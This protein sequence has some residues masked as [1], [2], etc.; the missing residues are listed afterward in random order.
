MLNS[1]IVRDRATEFQLLFFCN[2]KQ[3]KWSLL[4]RASEH[5]FAARDF[6]ERCD[7]KCNTLTLVK[8]ANHCIFGGYTG[9]KWS[10]NNGFVTDLHAFVFSLK[11]AASN[12][13]SFLA[14]CAESERAIYCKENMGPS[15]GV[16]DIS[17]S[18]MYNKNKSRL[19]EL[20][21]YQRDED[22]DED[23]E[24]ITLSDF[25]HFKT[26]DIEVYC[27]QYKELNMVN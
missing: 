4:Y 1:S 17:I 23:D 19:A 10:S 25:D 11:T 26:N 27:K 5:G 15:F 12:Q 7:G 22:F 3:Q 24:D 6:H 21:C 20:N 14:R 2:F 18:D 16:N 8:S 13:K 9:A